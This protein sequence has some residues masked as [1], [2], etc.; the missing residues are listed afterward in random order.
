MS[1][2]D[3]P[4]VSLITPFYNTA[5]HLEKCIRSVL[6]QT[7]S[8]FEYV[9]LDN[10]ST[11]GSSE[12]AQ[13]FAR[14][15]SRIRLVQP[16]EFVDQIPNYNRALQQ[17]SSDSRYCKLVQ[18]DD[19][20]YSRC[21][22]EM[23]NIIGRNPQVGIVSSYRLK[24]T[25]VRHQGLPPDRSVI[26]GREAARRHLLGD[27]F[28]F[29][30]PTSL[31]FRSD[32][33]RDRIPFYE[34]TSPHADT[35]ACYEILADWDMAFVHQVLTFSRVREDSI[36]SQQ[37]VYDPHHL[38][39][40]FL[41]VHQYADHYLR[42]GEAARIR[43]VVDR[44]YY[45]FLAREVLSRPGEEFWKYHRANLATADMDIRWGY[46]VQHLARVFADIALNPLNTARRL[47]GRLETA[48]AS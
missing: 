15:D 36:L 1:V 14:S 16:D 28:L 5:E 21:L 2:S 20:I 45:G 29:G 41:V 35:E 13:K 18:A 12:I 9:L 38:L 26:D 25:D 31:L 22:E 44:A 6:A 39:D 32:I 47:I 10:C 40:R 33:V 43:D 23:V 37:E 24:G 42:E 30:S 11:D 4:T 46:L 17:I 27:F 48:G 8:N 19:W 7:Y 3:G 34:V